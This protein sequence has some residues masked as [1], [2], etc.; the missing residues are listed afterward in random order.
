MFKPRL[1]FQN[2]FSS[3]SVLD[4]GKSAECNKEMRKKENM[5][6]STFSSTWHGFKNLKMILNIIALGILMVISRHITSINLIL[7]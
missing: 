1:T 2:S 5:Q 7:R 3:K 4:I 6:L